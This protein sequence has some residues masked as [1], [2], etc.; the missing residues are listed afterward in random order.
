M[1]RTDPSAATGQA[2]YDIDR[3]ACTHLATFHALREGVRRR[4][5]AWGCGCREFSVREVQR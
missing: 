1:S 5:S 3:C 4:C 2:P